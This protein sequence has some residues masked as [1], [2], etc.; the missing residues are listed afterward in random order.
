MHNAALCYG[1]GIYRPADAGVPLR[2]TPAQTEP[3]CFQILQ[4]ATR[5]RLEVNRLQITDVRQQVLP[6]TERAVTGLEITSDNIH[7]AKTA[8][9]LWDERLAADVWALLPHVRELD[10]Q[11]AESAEPAAPQ[12]RPCFLCGQLG[13]WHKYRVR[14]WFRLDS[15]VHEFSYVLCAACLKAAHALPVRPR[16][17]KR[18]PAQP[19][20]ARKR[21]PPGGNGEARKR[22]APSVPDLEK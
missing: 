18:Q 19:A 14:G 2:L 8:A 1:L 7:I 20:M 15:K 12:Q 17:T 5:A 3:V 9:S 22:P 11:P 21:K 16:P 10:I 4:N 6:T 13:A